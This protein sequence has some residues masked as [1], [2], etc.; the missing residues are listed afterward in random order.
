VYK[1]QHFFTFKICLKITVCLIQRKVATLASAG[2]VWIGHSQLIWEHF[3][4]EDS[5]DEN[6][7][8]NEEFLGF[9]EREDS[10][11]SDSDFTGF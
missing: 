1:T 6:S 2:A 9:R 3:L 11:D 7:D 4:Y 8:S 10:E 5:E